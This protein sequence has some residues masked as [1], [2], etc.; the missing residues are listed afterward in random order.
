M[1]KALPLGALLAL[2]LVHDARA[3]RNSSGTYA[4]PAG[5]PAIP[6]TLITASQWNSNFNDLGNELTDSLSR[7]GKGGM[8]APLRGL[9]GSQAAPAFS[10]TSET[11]TGL[12]RKSAAN[13]CLSVTN[14]EVACHTATTSTFNLPTTFAAMTTLTGSATQ[15]AV[16]LTPQADP[17]ALVNGMLWVDTGTNRVSA[18]VNGATQRLSFS[19]S[20]TRTDLPAVGQQVSSSCGHFTFSGAQA[21]TDV[22]NL[23]VS[24][25]TTGRPVMLV[26]QPDGS[27]VASINQQNLAQTWSVNFVRGATTLAQFGA[28]ANIS[29]ASM[30]QSVSHSAPLVFLDVVGAGTYTYKVQAQQAGGIFQM[31]NYRLVAFEL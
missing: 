31:E 22:T 25:T 23:S 27:A 19:G 2:F 30:S 11:G 7:G 28:D 3:T 5:N 17:S 8:L 6:N 9:D 14:V 12:F 13:A 26:L 18:R 21:A 4:L 10:F 24:L 20:I 16:L 15:A 1:R 29:G